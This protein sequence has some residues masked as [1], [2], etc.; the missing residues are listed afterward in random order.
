MFNPLSH[1]RYSRIHMQAVIEET[2]AEHVE[3]ERRIHSMNEEVGQVLT[4]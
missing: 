2:I 3:W 1:S 4:D